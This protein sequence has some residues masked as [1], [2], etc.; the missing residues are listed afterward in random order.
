MNP[1]SPKVHIIPFMCRL[2]LKKERNYYVQESSMYKI[3]YQ[4]L[5]Y[6]LSLV[7]EHLVPVQALVIG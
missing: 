6:F 7:P 1:V 5:I 4:R 2:L 3:W